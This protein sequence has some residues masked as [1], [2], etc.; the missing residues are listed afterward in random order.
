MQ[1]RLESISIFKARAIIVV[2]TI[3]L[4]GVFMVPLAACRPDEKVGPLAGRDA[5]SPGSASQ[6]QDALRT[7]ELNLSFQLDTPVV[8]TAGSPDEAAGATPVYFTP[9][10]PPALT[11]EAVPTVQFC[12]PLEDHNLADLLEIISFPYDP[13]P[14][15][16]DTGHHGVDFAYYRRGERLSILGVP[17][18]SVLP[19]KIAVA[20][21]N[22]APYGFMV[23]VETPFEKLPVQAVEQLGIPSQQSLYLLY[24]HMNEPPIVEEG[25]FVDCGQR[26]GYVGN[27]PEEWSSAPHL[28]FEAR[29]G[30]A[31]GQFS[32][33][34]FYD[35][36]SQVDQMEKYSLWR[37]SGEYTLLD[38]LA[39]LVYGLASDSGM[40]N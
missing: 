31:G 37:M 5:Q 4:V 11:P 12:S 34:Q 27:T 35:K 16:K 10:P 24:A 32:G 13:P 14:A 9:S 21:Q 33:M 38:P 23:I 19:G 26:L 39:L 30:P 18:Q 29:Y 2:N 8:A 1:N 40:E 7:P 20:N 36:R 28:H 22:L 15:G 3:L 17:I 25:S 6:V